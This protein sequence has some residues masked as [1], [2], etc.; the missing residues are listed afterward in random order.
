MSATR[1]M[2]QKCVKIA[3]KMRQT[4]FCF[5]LGKEERNVTFQNVSTSDFQS[6]VGESFGET[7]GEFPAKED[8]FRAFF[9]G[10]IVRSMFH[11]NSTADSTI[12]LHYEVLGGGGPQNASKNASKN[13][14]NTFG[15]EHLLDDTNKSKSGWPRTTLRCS[16]P[17]D[18]QE[19]LTRGIPQSRNA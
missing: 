2:R 4:G 8:D 19:P 9:A 16:P 17:L 6:E 15:G 10:K 14:R 5:I 1:G 7:G 13:A 12:K 3:S 18:A 11:Q